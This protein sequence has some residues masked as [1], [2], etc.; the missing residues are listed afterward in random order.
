MLEAEYLRSLEG[1]DADDDPK[2]AC[3]ALGAVLHDLARKRCAGELSEGRFIDAV[4]YIQA[5]YVA[6]AGFTLTVCNTLDNWTVFQLRQNSREEPCASFEFLP[7]TGEFRLLG[8]ERDDGA[9][10]QQ[11]G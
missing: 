9:G 10:P 2:A 1:M 11:A 4:L 6:P 8:L 5:N 3:H 7:H